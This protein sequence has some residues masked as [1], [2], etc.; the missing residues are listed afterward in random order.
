MTLINNKFSSLNK[1]NQADVY[2]NLL[3]TRPIAKT[4]FI[5]I[6]N[7]PNNLGYPRLGIIISKKLCKKANKRNKLKRIIREIFRTHK[8][9]LLSTDILFRLKNNINFFTNLEYAQQRIFIQN[10]IIFSIIYRLIW[11]YN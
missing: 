7:L 4:E 1:L 9:I 3:S 6:H 11:Y 8:Q 5:N 10:I 2:K